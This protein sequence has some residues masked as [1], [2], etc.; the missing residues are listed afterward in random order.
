VLELGFPQFLY[1]QHLPH[2]AVVLLDR[3][4]AAASG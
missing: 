2:L 1:Y 3:L 4:T